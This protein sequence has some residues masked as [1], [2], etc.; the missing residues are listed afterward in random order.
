MVSS[1]PAWCGHRRRTTH[2]FSCFL[3]DVHETFLALVCYFTPRGRRR[4]YPPYVALDW[5]GWWSPWMHL[6]NACLVL[7]LV[8]TK[9][10]L[11]LILLRGKDT[12]L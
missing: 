3:H 1:F 10:W 8:L 2:I 9:V 7:M 12:L 6:L 5:A 11:L 4:R